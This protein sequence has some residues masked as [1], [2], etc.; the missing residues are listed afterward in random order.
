MVTKL[1]FYKQREAS[2]AL[3]QVR[4][5]LEILDDGSIRLDKKAKADVL[6]YLHKLD[7]VQSL[8][9]QLEAEN[10]SDL[11][12]EN[13]LF[14]TVQKRFFRN[15][16]A[17]L[18]ALGG[19]AALRA[20]RPE[21]ASMTDS[22]WWFL[23][24]YVAEK[25]SQ[26]L[27]RFLKGAG[28]LGFIAL[29][30]IILLNT[31]LKPDPAV[32]AAKNHYEA[33]FSLLLQEG[34]AVGAL[35]EAN[36]ALAARPGDFDS[37]M[38]KAVALEL[39]NQNSEAEQVY[40]EAAAL[41]PGREYVSLGRGRIY[42]QL[43]DA[44]KSLSLAEESISLNPDFAEAHFLAGQ[45]YERL[46]DIQAAFA[47]MELASDLALEQENDTLYAIIRVNMG[48]LTNPGGGSGL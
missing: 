29:V 10:V 42:L 21:T 14:D 9:A 41:A 30:V 19:S 38:L 22:P 16:S 47:A 32:I 23:D 37:L 4:E 20:A 15:S 2:S 26:Q 8:L 46:G 17:I 34:D 33:G 28:I 48:Y 18:T 44:E 35:I 43:G 27:Q 25:R 24:S 3:A 45:S 40:D 5:Q 36:N 11:R 6:N 7:T 13:S 31:V 39:S 12:G 1:D